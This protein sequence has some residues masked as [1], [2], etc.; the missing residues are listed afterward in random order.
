MSMKK[1]F[2]LVNKLEEFDFQQY[3]NKYLAD[4][5]ITVGESL[6]I[7]TDYYD[8]I[9][10]WNYRKILKNIFDKKNIILFH[11]TN[12]PQG[13]GWAPI[14]YT[15]T[16]GLEQYTISGIFAADEVDS[17]DIIVQA[18]FK[19]K[20]NYTAE[21]IREW[22]DEICIMLIKKIFEI[23]QEKEIKGR[24][25]QGVSSFNTRRKPEDNEIN[26]NVKFADVISHLRACEK[27]HP[28][29][30]VYKGTKYLITVEPETKPTFPDDLE[31]IFYDSIQ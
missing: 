16:K 20:D 24:K 8:L 21:I 11:S 23:F 25:Q 28:A 1:V 6:P 13:K 19:I 5:N 2:F 31:I 9:I 15:L 26:P 7:D 22:D 12:L 3:L 17:G 30:F 10:L 29:F 4:V 18:K 14:Y 27:K